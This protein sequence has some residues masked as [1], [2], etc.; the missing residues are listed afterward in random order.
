[1]RGEKDFLREK[2]NSYETKA[3]LLRRQHYA[4]FKTTLNV[5]SDCE[6]SASKSSLFLLFKILKKVRYI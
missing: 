6:N 1:M 2:Y 3:I 5:N 4:E